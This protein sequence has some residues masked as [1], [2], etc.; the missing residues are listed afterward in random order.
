[1]RRQSKRTESEQVSREVGA[2]EEFDTVIRGC[3]V[4]TSR[5]RRTADIGITSGRVAAVGERLPRRGSLTIDADGLMALPGGVD[6]HVHLMDPGS[7]DREDFP[8]GTRAAAVAGV[9]TIIEHSHGSPVRDVT[10]LRAKRKYLDGRSNVDFALAAHAWPGNEAAVKD[11]WAEGA[12]F[13]KAFTCTTHG[14]PGHD[15]SSLSRHFQAAAQ[16]GAAT[17]VHCEDESLTEDAE[18]VLRDMGR[19]DGGVLWEWRSRAA[20]VIAAAV[21]AIVCR[22]AGATATI[23]HVSHPEVAEYIEQ[24]RRRGAALYAET[25]P[26]YLLLREPELAELGPFRKFTPPV[27]ARHDA[28]EADMWALLRSGCLTH[29]SS[30]HAPAT[31][32]QKLDGSL[33]EVHFGLPGIDTTM[34][35]LLDAAAR[36]QLA[37]EDIARLYSEVP[38]RIYGLW[39]QK[40]AI[41]V[42]ADADIALVDPTEVH[43]LSDARVISKAGWTPYAGRVVTGRV[44]MTLLRG[45]LIADGGVLV[46]ERCG[47]IAP[48]HHAAAPA[49]SMSQGS[50]AR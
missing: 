18:K 44:K 4:I 35:L 15:I 3:T 34:T 23:A 32:E 8:T 39:P 22:K 21:A 47:V 6:T 19:A 5:G 46:S 17:L 26:Q 38:A 16:V 30:D 2:M 25:C 9:T 11:L 31:R 37:Y 20:E 36:Q 48:R 10:E 1:M 50:F 42:G 29:I 41:A 43:R 27:R 13:F 24:E 28:D 45:A 49:A 40:G 7:T 14:I 33:W 12:A